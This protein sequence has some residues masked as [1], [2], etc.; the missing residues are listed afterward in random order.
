MPLSMTG[1]ARRPRDCIS[2]C[3]TTAGA[4]PV[5][6]GHRVQPFDISRRRRSMPPV[7]IDVDVRRRADDAIAQLALDAGHQRERDDERHHAD[8]HAER[9]RR[10]EISEMN[11]CR[12]RAVR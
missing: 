9:S 11:A 6:A 1:A 7:L 10:P 2:P 8:A 4:A 5:D 12:R 3:P